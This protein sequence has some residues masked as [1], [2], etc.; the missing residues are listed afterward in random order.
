MCSCNFISGLGLA[1]MSIKNR[2]KRLFVGFIAPI[3]AAPVGL[4]IYGVFEPGGNFELDGV[5]IAFLLVLFFSTA[6]GGLQS[7]IYSM[8]MEF[9]VNPY[10]KSNFLC[11]ALSVVLGFLSGLP[12][13]IGYGYFGAVVGLCVGTFLRM[14]YL[15]SVSSG[16]SK[17]SFS[18]REK[19]QRNKAALIK[20]GLILTIYIFSYF[21]PVRTMNLLVHYSTYQD[22]WTLFSPSYGQCHTVTFPRME[23][24]MFNFIFA[25][26]IQIVG[27]GVEIFYLPLRLSEAAYWQYHEPN[28]IVY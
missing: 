24:T 7:F 2:T 4:L 28:P 20:Y 16:V 10:V 8:L 22:C 9:I 12:L 11:V 1:F 15:R 3:V 23:V 14:D 13:A 21:I 27:Y 18:L 19:F 26:P 17:P 6:G 25:L 5:V